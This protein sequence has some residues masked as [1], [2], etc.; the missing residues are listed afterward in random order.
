MEVRVVPV[1]ADTEDAICMP[2]QRH[3]AD[4]GVEV[5]PRQRYGKQEAAVGRVRK[6]RLQAALS[7]TSPNT[8]I[9]DDSTNTGKHKHNC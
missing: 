8:I 2:S 5:L 6:K 4:P 1:D 3:S 9:S 7:A